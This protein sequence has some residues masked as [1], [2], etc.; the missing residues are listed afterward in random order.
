MFRE[1][2][3]GGRRAGRRDRNTSGRQLFLYMAMEPS[4][5][6]NEVSLNLNSSDLPTLMVLLNQLA[7]GQTEL[8]WGN[9]NEWDQHVGLFLQSQNLRFDQNLRLM[10]LSPQ[11]GQAVDALLQ[12]ELN[13]QNPPH[14]GNALARFVQRRT[15]T[16]SLQYWYGEDSNLRRLA[17]L[18]ADSFL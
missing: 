13:A 12:Q 4:E 7:P 10:R 15:R 11:D 16:H 18:L 2:H 1:Q 9:F 14:Q 3:R 8:N 5:L 6:V 17:Y